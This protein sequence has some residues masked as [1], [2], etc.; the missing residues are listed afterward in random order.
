V[1]GR[2]RRAGTQWRTANAIGQTELSR[3]KG[4]KRARLRT[5]ACGLKGSAAHPTNTGN[6]PNKAA[7]ARRR[8]QAG[9]KAPKLQGRTPEGPRPSNSEKHIRQVTGSAHDDPVRAAEAPRLSGGADPRR[10][11]R[12]M[13]A[14]DPARSLPPRPFAVS[15]FRGAIGPL[16]DLRGGGLGRLSKM[17]P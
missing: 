17:E 12:E 2:T 3:T 9:Q 7:A 14:A 15:R 8:P 5:D 13:D 1:A 11:R 10:H 6:G 4:A 16:E